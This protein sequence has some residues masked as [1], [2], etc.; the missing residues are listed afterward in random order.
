MSSNLQSKLIKFVIACTLFCSI[1]PIYAATPWLHVEGNQIKDPAGN[2]VVL[3]GAATIDLAWVEWRSG[4]IIPLIDRLTDANDTQGDYKGWHTKVIRLA[5][6]PSDQG[7]AGVWGFDEDPNLYYEYLLRPVVDY[8][9]SKGLYVIIDWHYIADTTSHVT[10]TNAFWEYVAPRFANDSHV[11][12]ELF[13]E[14][15]GSESWSV[16]KANMQAWTDIVRTYAPNNLILVG[17]KDWC[18]NIAPYAT[19]PVTGGNIVYVS[20]IYPYHWIYNNYYH[21]N[22]ILTCAAAHP[23]IV[24]E[25]GFM[26][27]GIYLLDGTVTNY[28]QPWMAFL[29]E[30]KISN[31]A[32]CADYDWDPPMFNTDWTLRGGDNYMGCF[33]KDTLYLR[34][35]DDQPCD[36]ASHGPRPVQAEMDTPRNTILN[37]E[38]GYLAFEHEVYFGTDFNDVNDANQSDPEY[39]GNQFLSDCSYDPCGLLGADANYYWRVDEVNGPNTWKGPVWRFKTGK[40]LSVEDFDSYAGDTGLRAVWEPNFN[41]GA[42]VS[43]E[44]IKVQSGKSMKYDYEDISSSGYYSEVDA[45]TLDLPS[46]IGTDWTIGGVKM[47]TLQFY[48]QTGNDANEPMYVRL[49]DGDSS[50]MVTYGDGDE[51]TDD[52]KEPWWHEWNIALADF[53]G[54]D[55]NDVRRI[56]IGFGDQAG[57]DAEGN[58]YFDNIRSY[59]PRCLAGMTTADV[60]SDCFIDYSDLGILADYWLVPVSLT[61]PSDSNLVGEWMLETDACDTSGYNNNGTLV[62]PPDWV[63]GRHADENGKA[64]KFLLSDADYVACGT[65]A[66]LNLTTKG[67]IAAWI[68]TDNSSDSQVNTYVSKGHRTTLPVSTGAYGIWDN[69]SNNIEFFIYEGTTLYSAASA[70][71]SSFNGVWHHVAGTYDGSQIKLYI[72]GELKA[73]STYTGTINTNTKR[74]LMGASEAGNSSNQTYY[75]NGKID[76]V[77][78]YSRALSQAEIMYLAEKHVDLNRDGI[79]NIRD[80]ASLA[81]KWLEEDL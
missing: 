45:N 72:D 10:K 9:K 75:H 21:T 66:S 2:Q 80:F 55:L 11:I 76:E 49:T 38:P 23:I 51:D 41:S 39:K 19:D 16:V 54:V 5:L 52:L 31:T 78:I 33:V 12:F 15:D 62:G 73:T 6:Y 74:L 64:L 18:Q 36:T 40:G 26:N 30:N 37:W 27:P 7:G 25:W 71:D 53:A 44:I 65:N 17:G 47:L 22:Q 28:G 50:A 61:A 20:H 1:T 29:E 34:R 57:P 13:N 32:W 70:V 42:D 3:R 56:T 81:A 14:P 60:D 69:A 68:Q 59:P 35:N 4:G 46:G 77:R 48:G 79:V 58:V 67:T 24:T 63:P 8:C 43:L